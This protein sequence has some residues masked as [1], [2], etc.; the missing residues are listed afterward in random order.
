[1]LL[2]SE[3]LGSGH[4]TLFQFDTTLDPFLMVNIFRATNVI[5]GLSL[6]LHL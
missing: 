4:K 5:L 2:Y 1:M 3:T 6:L